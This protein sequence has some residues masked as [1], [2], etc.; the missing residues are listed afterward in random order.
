MKL[1]LAS[2]IAPLKT[3]F[4]ISR[5]AKIEAK[6]LCVTLEQDGH[7]GRGECVPYPRYKDTIASVTAEIEDLRRQIEANIDLEALQSM[8]PAGAAR[9]ALDCALWDLNAKRLSR[10]VW[11][12]ANLPAP[13][14][15]DT[16][17]TISLDSPE[18]MAA[19]ARQTQGR[20]LKLK[21]GS[22]DD[23]ARL[24]AVHR[25]RPN[26][27]L[28]IDG[29]EGL[30]PDEFPAFAARAAQLGVAMI[31]Q[32]FPAG[33]DDA[34]TR[35]DSPVPV[36]ADESAHTSTDIAELAK[37]YHAVN[38]KL[39]KT[40]GLT[41]AIKMVQAARAANMQIMIGCMV[42]GSLSMAPAMMLASLADMVDLDGPL[43]LT[44]D[45][46]NG[47]IYQGGVV[48]PPVPALWG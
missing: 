30:R 14:P 6:T 44:E 27:R 41:E 18:Q 35:M 16:A 32:P 5:G 45:I 36:C 9:C 33:Q 10:P 26:A 21:L 17:V 28:I 7:T 2:H 11:K 47:L 1:T 20:L 15:V 43:W 37:R 23:L 38:V 31:E 4:A 34:L 3:A 25:A 22:E 19:S 24:E 42:A 8:L 40:G 13:K 46:A 29:N 39:D 48:S 12:L